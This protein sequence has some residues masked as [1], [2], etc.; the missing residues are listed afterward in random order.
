[1]SMTVIIAACPRKRLGSLHIDASADVVVEI[2][3]SVSMR[4]IR[5]C[6]HSTHI[7]SSFNPSCLLTPAMQFPSVVTIRDVSINDGMMCWM[8]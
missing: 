7:S 4:R 1:M 6:M 3:G 2:V 5:T 8:A